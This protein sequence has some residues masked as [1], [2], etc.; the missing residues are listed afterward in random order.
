MHA[1][2]SFPSK[3]G[4]RSQK[5]WCLWE[6]TGPKCTSVIFGVG[7]EKDKVGGNGSDGPEHNSF[8]FGF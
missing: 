3:E 7:E 1:F 4:M 2:A 8:H 5:I 6:E